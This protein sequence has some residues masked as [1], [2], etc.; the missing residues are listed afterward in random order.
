MVKGRGSNRNDRLRANYNMLKQ[1]G[2]ST[3]DAK[4][5][6]GASIEK[7]NKAMVEKVAPPKSERH[8]AIRL[9]GIPMIDIK[10]A[11]KAYLSRYTYKVT[12]KRKDGTIDWITITNN[13]KLSKRAIRDISREII[14]EDISDGGDRYGGD[15]NVLVTSIRVEYGIENLG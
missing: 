4:R 10:E 15:S 3:E 5:L 8:A 12:F 2:F 7:I 14:I 1:I 6:R 11:D 9:I 13:K